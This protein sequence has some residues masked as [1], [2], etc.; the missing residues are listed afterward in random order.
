MCKWMA[1]QKGEKLLRGRKSWR[2]L[3]I[4]VLKVRDTSKKK[5]VEGVVRNVD[6]TTK[7]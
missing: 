6:L 5:A 7:Q 1:E 4:Y 3:I 2:A